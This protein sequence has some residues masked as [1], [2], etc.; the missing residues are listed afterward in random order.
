MVKY[1]MPSGRTREQIHDVATAA[2]F[3]LK[4]AATLTLKARA[5]QV[6]G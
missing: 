5:P 1:R 6:L 3:R 2:A 4:P